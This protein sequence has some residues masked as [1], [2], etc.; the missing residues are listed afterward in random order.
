MNEE[1]K[2]KNGLRSVNM[3][4]FPKATFSVEIEKDREMLRIMKNLSCEK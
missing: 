4:N 2:G 1:C 3:I